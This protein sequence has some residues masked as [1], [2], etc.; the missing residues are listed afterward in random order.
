MDF[1][2]SKVR[3]TDLGQEVLRPGERADNSW[4]QYN[5]KTRPLTVEQWN[6]P[7]FVHKLYIGY[8]TWPKKLQV[9]ASPIEEVFN[10]EKRKLSDIEQEI[11]NFFNDPQNVDKLIHYF[12]LE[13]KKGKEKFNCS[14]FFLF[15]F[16]FRS[17][18]DAFLKHFWPHLK[19]LAADSQESSQRCA[20][21]I[22]A[23]L[24]QGTKH[25]PFE[26]VSNMWKELIPIINV[27]LSN[28]SV[29]SIGNWSLSFAIA[30][31][32]LDP[33]RLHWL[34]ESL[35]DESPLGESE[36]SLVE[37]GRLNVLQVRISYFKF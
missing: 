20:S 30:Q 1:D 26:M 37:C 28:L 35:M 10:L 25:W 18:G 19:R 11:Y 22:I 4:L 12:S 31:K 32:S 34:L 9:Y 8:Y 29:D 23:G 7:R 2:L 36:G 33:N 13:E 5:S 15:K 21:E 3:Q 17:Y 16:L 24:I 14:N 27:A 6:E